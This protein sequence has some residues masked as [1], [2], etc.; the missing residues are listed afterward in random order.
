MLQFAIRIFVIIGV[1]FVVSYIIIPMW[2]PSIKNKKLK[3]REKKAVEQV[4]FLDEKMR[5]LKIEK[6]RNTKAKEVRN[7]ESRN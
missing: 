6:E 7:F 3:E 5:V 2:F 4:S 1:I